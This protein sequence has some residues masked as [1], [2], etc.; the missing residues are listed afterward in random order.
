MNIKGRKY[1]ETFYFW[2][3]RLRK[4]GLF[5]DK[6]GTL[7]FKKSIP[8][9]FLASV[10]SLFYV[11]CLKL[12]SLACFQ[13]TMEKVGLALGGRALSFALC[14]MGCS[15]GLTLAIV[16]AVRAIISNEAPPSLGKMVLPAGTE[17]GES[18]SNGS[19]R[20]YLDF[21]P[22][23]EVNQTP[24]PQAPPLPIE[25]G[26]VPPANAVAF[27]EAGPSQVAPPGPSSTGLGPAEEQASLLIR[28]AEVKQ[29]LRYFLRAHTKIEPKFTFVDQVYRD[30]QISNSD[31][32]RL[33]KMKA[34]MDALRQCEGIQNGSKAAKYLKA[35][36]K[37][38]EQN[39]RLSW[40]PALPPTSSFFD[41]LSEEVQLFGNVGGGE[42]EVNQPVQQAQGTPPE[43]SAGTSSEAAGPF[44]V[45]PS[46][47]SS[48]TSSWFE[49]A[50]LFYS[51]NMLG[52]QGEEFSAPQNPVSAE[53]PGQDNQPPLVV[54]QAGP[55][56]I[57]PPGPSSTGVGPAPSMPSVRHRIDEVLSSFNQIAMRADILGS[58]H[59]KLGL[60][61]AS[62]QKLHQIMNLL[63]MLKNSEGA[64]RPKS[65]SQ[66]GKKL[67]ELLHDWSR[68]NPGQ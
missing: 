40:L 35:S 1:P 61:T 16:F 58:L 20:Q 8:F 57:A 27:S 47:P 66:A 24:G 59:D 31:P 21:S 62:P 64:E 29:E 44:R 41:G 65:G 18:L 28:Q 32:L 55:S 30:L 50:E 15:G 2:I 49:G 60:K 45:S 10:C 14:K 4:K 67:V 52:I 26:T 22:D 46:K 37:E 56:Q 3:R 12:G 39:G 6:Y 63:D 33:S 19:W 36:M 53:T 17:A 23:K 5:L 68:N 34:V 43:A 9:L 13:T 11:L 42:P 25:S 7:I 48:P 51:K 54:E 38:W